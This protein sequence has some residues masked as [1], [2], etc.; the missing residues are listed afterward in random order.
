MLHLHKLLLGGIQSIL[1]FVGLTFR[2][3]KKRKPQDSGHFK[4]LQHMFGIK[5]SR[6]DR[7]LSLAKGS[8]GRGVYQGKKVDVPAAWLRPGVVLTGW[9]LWD[10]SCFIIGQGMGG[11]GF[12]DSDLLVLESG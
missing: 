11:T 9:L 12:G 4:H 2:K 3:K 8:C 6:G 7:G 5:S 10:R 1:G